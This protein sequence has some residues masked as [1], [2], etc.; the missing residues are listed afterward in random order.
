MIHNSMAKLLIIA[1]CFILSIEISAQT[2]VAAH[3]KLKVSDN[4]IVDKN[5]KSYQLRGMSFFWSNWM[6]KYWTYNTIKWLRDDWH[7][8][9]VRAAMAVEADKG[10]ISNPDVELEKMETVIEA[11]IDLGVYIIVDWHSHS[12]LS[13]ETEEC[14]FFEY[15]VE[16]YGSYPNLLY[17]LYN[18]PQYDGWGELKSYYEKILKSI[19]GKNGDGI[20]ILGTPFYDQNVEDAM[21]NTLDSDD[22]VAYCLHFYAGTHNFTDKI[23]AVCNKNKCLF[24]SEFGTCDAS[25]NGGYNENAT[26]NWLNMLDEKNVSWCNW[27]ISDKE[28]T[29]SIVK[30]NASVDGN[31][32]LQE[33]TTSGNFIRTRLRSYSQDETPSNIAPFI[34]SSPQNQSVPEGSSARF[35]IEVAGHSPSYQWYFDGQ[36]IGGATQSTLV[37]DN[38]TSENVGEYYCVISNQ[39]GET[40]SK[41]AS[42]ETRNRSTYYAQPITLPGMVECEDYDN[43]GQDIGYYDVSAGNSGYAYRYEDV[44]IEATNNGYAVGYTEA[45]EWLSY[46]VNVSW[47]G[48]YTITFCYAGESGTLKMSID[49]DGT[50]I[51][52]ETALQSTGNWT[53][54]TTKQYKVNLTKG[55]HLLKLNFVSSGYNA[56]YMKFESTPQGDI[57]PVI[58][59]QPKNAKA[60]EGNRVVLTTT[61]IGAEPIAYQWYKDGE[62][63]ANAN[64]STYSIE[65]LDDEECGTYHLVASNWLGEAISTKVDVVIDDTNNAYQGVAATIPGTI[66]GVYFDEGGEGIGF[67]ETSAANEG[68]SDNAKNKFRN[69]GVDTEVSSNNQAGYTIGYITN[70]EWL[71]Y[72]VN[73]LYTGTYRVKFNVASE[74][75]NPHNMSLLVDEQ[76]AID[77]INI[78][79]T[80]SW[81]SWNNT[82]EYE[83]ELTTGIHVIKLQIKNGDFNFSH[84]SFDIDGLSTYKLTLDKGW[85]LMSMPI[86]VGKTDVASLFADLDGLIIKS[87]SLYYH[88]SQPAMFNT[89]LK[90]E[91]GKGYLIYNPNEA[92]T[93]QWTGIEIDENIDFAKLPQG[94][95]LVGINKDVNVNT[96]PANVEI[97]KDF[98]GFFEPNQPSSLQTLTKGNGYFIKSK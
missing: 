57:A 87:D 30:P 37:V 73:V 70:N 53:K 47:S 95:N 88:A 69:G 40:T 17:E 72:T 62:A 94:W 83:L 93:L 22:N 77:N 71:S 23:G 59:M 43:G 86:K 26:E 92:K 60:K 54:F 81:T 64:K 42:L 31:W 8:N 19:R 82:T 52:N 16:K 28:E 97:V 15:I 91:S 65:S 3:G 58:T 67:H 90:L 48:E 41:K 61:V 27:A 44:D 63:I 5:N 25:G 21:N 56:D 4:Q 33:L 29:A 74:N 49:I 34:T 14:A 11:A 20:A 7:C 2:P 13:Y 51:V 76:T 18:E 89:L 66:Y 46:S 85:N 9:V 12:T 39:Y 35:T 32:S 75:Y 10:Y 84:M 50:T 80:G 45:G 68:A 98:D 36:K 96:L 55:E 79:G 1:I 78:S 6:G 38:A 24:V